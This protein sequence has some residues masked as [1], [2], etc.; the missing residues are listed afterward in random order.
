[1]RIAKTK[2]RLLSVVSLD[3]CGGKYCTMWSLTTANKEASLRD[4]CF[5]VLHVG[6]KLRDEYLLCLLPALVVPLKT[7]KLF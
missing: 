1:M 4:G 6:N 5:C 7:L 3:Y 2:T